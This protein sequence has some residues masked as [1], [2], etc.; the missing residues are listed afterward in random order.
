MSLVN[1]SKQL[2]DEI[3]SGILLHKALSIE[4]QA[5]MILFNKFEAE[6]TRSV[7]FRS[8]AT[9]A[10]NCAEYEI[11]ERMVYC[12]LSGVH[13]P[14]EIEEELCQVRDKLLAL[15]SLSVEEK[16]QYNYLQILRD[17]AINIRLKPSLPKY[18]DAVFIEDIVSV[19]KTV[20]T[21]FDN[22]IRVNFLQT[23]GIEKYGDK[24]N[25]A[26][27]KL[28]NDFPLL[29][30]NSKFKSFGASL[31]TDAI[32][33]TKEKYEK[34]VIE[35]R[36]SLFDEFKNDVIYIDYSL[37]KNLKYLQNK[38]SDD[39]R[40]LIYSG[41]LDIFNDSKNY[42]V[43]FT[44]SEYEEVIKVGSSIPKDKK[45]QL[46]KK[47]LNTKESEKTLVRTFGMQSKGQKQ[48]KKSDIIVSEELT[49]AEFSYRTSHLIYQKDSL[50]LKKELVLTIKY[51]NREFSINYPP[52][53]IEVISNTHDGVLLEFSKEC[54]NK[55][56]LLTSL[57]EPERTHETERLLN[58][59]SE[60][61]FSST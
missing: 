54:Y 16:S 58:N 2:D 3:A 40:N 31:S 29:Y 46:L 11:A 7:L 52:F 43:T 41:Y 22:F 14:I 32:V 49:N 18:A 12:G 21:S 20:K 61:V 36:K 50:D 38:Y 10:Y 25:Y 33:V 30:V 1:E 15:K 48:I 19:L 4:V 45:E 23:F 60:F 6:P 39:E 34:D 57:S 24:T 26:I 59:F 37:D 44:D 28:R 56:R 42:N 47:T 35:W 53:E 27:S 8:A 51:E 17:N 13:L 9:L 5:A 55:Y